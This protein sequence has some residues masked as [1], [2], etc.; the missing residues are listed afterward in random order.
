[1]PEQINKP[2][3]ISTNE[4][5]VALTNL[6]LSLGEI[7][8]MISQAIRRF[9][10]DDQHEQ[11]YDIQVALAGTM[12]T[13]ETLATHLAV[14]SSMGRADEIQRHVTDFFLDN[15]VFAEKLILNYLVQLD[16]LDVA[17]FMAEVLCHTP[18]Y[19]LLT[20][21]EK[22]DTTTID[23]LTLIKRFVNAQAK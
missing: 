9:D 20:L 15:N 4:E 18:Q 23:P 6:W 8:T 13:V 1:M 7:T 12:P 22:C 14:L 3:A 11:L 19:D 17:G 21:A 16:D 10:E 2:I 5:L